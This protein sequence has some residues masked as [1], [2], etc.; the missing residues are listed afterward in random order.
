[1]MIRDLD[2]DDVPDRVRSLLDDPSRLAEMGA[3]MLQAAKPDAA[4][5]IAE[6]LIALAR[7]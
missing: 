5:E 4:E 3:A 2:L 1:M 6:G 7:P